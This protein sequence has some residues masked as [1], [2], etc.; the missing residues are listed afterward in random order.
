MKLYIVR[1]GETDW[2]LARKVQ[3]SAD[4]PLNAYGEYLARETA[5]GLRE[6][7]FDIAYTSPLI[8][9]RRTAELILEGRN[10]PLIDA[11]EIREMNFGAYEGMCCSGSGR[12]PESREFNKFF[13]DTANYVPA[14]GGETVAQLMRRTAR[15]LHTLAENTELQDKTILVTTHGAAMMA[16]MNGIKG[17]EDVGKFWANDVTPNCG[18]TIADVRDGR[19]EILKENIVYYKEPVR[20]WSVEE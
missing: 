17:N 13:T 15:F 19:I 11:E 16:M 20:A 5:A 8:R 4:I 7:P 12:A 10:V 14:E 3:G 6:V 18:V 1:H 9:A 2:N